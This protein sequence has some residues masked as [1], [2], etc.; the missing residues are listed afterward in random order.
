MKLVSYK[1]DNG[2]AWGVVNGNLVAEVSASLG[3]EWPDLAAM[4][5]AGGMARVAAAI[6]NAPTRSLDGL[7]FLP[8]V[9]NPSKILCIGV[10]YAMHRE[11]MG[12]SAFEEPTVFTRFA[13]TLIGHDDA[14]GLPAISHELDYEGEL[15]IIIGRG[16]RAIDAADA[17]DHI[18]GFTCFNDATLRD[19][20][21]HSS[22][23]TPG[24]NF[25]RTG[26]LGPWL[27][28]PDEMGALPDKRLQT[29]LNGEVVQDT[30]L[31]DMI[32]D[33]PKIIAYCSAFTPLRP[34]DVIATGTPAGV[35]AKRKPPLWMKPGD[36]VEVEIDGIG[37]L[38]N[39]I[40]PF[41]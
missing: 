17:L 27:V 21:R 14:I 1:G 2:P 39:T 36:V 22:Q 25:P 18:A 29:R 11:E 41:E 15:A 37:C 13:D 35:G 20:Q 10:N 9:F 16:G 33:V 24:K 23:F 26:P 19:W 28:T 30:V 31:A 34:G 4:I 5:A 40:A 6:G 12:R 7:A 3:D 8:V 38:R 32:F